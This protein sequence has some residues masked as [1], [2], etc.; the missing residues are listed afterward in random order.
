M[1]NGNILIFSTQR[2][3]HTCACAPRCDDFRVDD[4]SFIII[5]FQL[6]I[7]L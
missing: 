5:L 4:E 3:W 1:H 6:I 2:L 7:R